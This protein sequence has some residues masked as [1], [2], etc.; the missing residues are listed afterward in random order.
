MNQETK[1]LIERYYQTQEHRIA[2]GNQVR[3]LKEAGE[4]IKS[5]GYYVDDTE[6]GIIIKKL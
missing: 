5:K 6:N 3:A 4:E 2:I 1:Y